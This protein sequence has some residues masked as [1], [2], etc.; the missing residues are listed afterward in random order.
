VAGADRKQGSGL[1][2]PRRIN[3]WVGVLFAIG[4]LCFFLGPFPG[5]VDLVGSS[6]D[7]VVFFVGS[8]FFTSAAL[9]Q[10][11][12]SK[13]WTADWWASLIQL[14]GTVYFNVDTFRAMQNSFDTADVNRVVWRPEAIG[15]ICFLVSGWIALRAVRHL[16]GT[17][18]Y[19]IAVVNF[20]GC[21][22][23]GI[24]T[25]GGYVLPSTGDELN[26]LA[27]NAGTALGALCFLIGALMLLPQ[28]PET[29]R[30]ADVEP[31]PR[32]QSP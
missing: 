22:L 11:I 1:R 24:S 23:F 26:L 7:G 17:R 16:R 8:L 20:A 12:G 18:D 5:F 32:M 4:S 27:A 10:L 9:L 30:G 15:S 2:G 25:V 21:V 13:R 14:A 6:A 19:R 3:W 28:P 31:A 29:K